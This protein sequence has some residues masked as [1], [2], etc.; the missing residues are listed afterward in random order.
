[1]K[2]IITALLL[3]VCI[4]TIQAAD[5]ASYE[6]IDLLLSLPG[7]VPP[8]IFEDAVIFTAPSSNR[9]VGVSFAYEGFSRVYWFRKLMIP[10]DPAEIAAEGKKKNI[11]P[12]RDSGILFHVQT[13][14]DGI[15]DLDYRVIIDGLWTFD[16][17]N[18]QVVTGSAGIRNSR[19]TIPVRQGI[20]PTVDNS[21]GTL[22]FN[23]MASPGE[24]VTVGGSF[25][26]WDPFMYEMKETGKGNY[27]MTLPLPPGTY[28][29][30]FFYRGERYTDPNNPDMIYTKDGKVVSQAQIK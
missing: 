28:Q 21:A 14:P 22:R 11:D 5:L 7:P 1:M 27:S 20:P 6:F 19:V 24:I 3:I 13:I 30:V 25:N 10:K 16:P 9:S 8:V 23:F 17:G 18:P 12:N 2:R 15:K 4:G 29:Y 26:N